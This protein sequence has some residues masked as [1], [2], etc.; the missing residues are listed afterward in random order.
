MDYT[1]LTD[2]ST[3]WSRIVPHSEMDQGFLQSQHG[4]QQQQKKHR[5]ISLLLAEEE[6]LAGGEVPAF[7]ALS[8]TYGRI[9]K[10]P[11]TDDDG[12]TDPDSIP[13]STN[14]FAIYPEA[15]VRNR[16]DAEDNRTKRRPPQ[17]VDVDAQDSV[18]TTPPLPA[19]GSS[20][21]ES[22]SEGYD[23]W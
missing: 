17:R 15:R 19:G 4:L 6:H 9:P 22:S 21:G 18:M 16:F 2:I 1:I 5:F 8:W 7:E 12:L 11:W 13:S 14:A 20:E 3:L 10:G 23:D